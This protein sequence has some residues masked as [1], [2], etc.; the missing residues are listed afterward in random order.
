[1]ATV[2]GKR[3]IYAGCINSSSRTPLVEEGKALEADIVA[4][5]SVTVTATGIQKNANAKTVKGVPFIVAAQVSDFDGSNDLDGAWTQNQVMMAFVPQEDEF[6]NVL[7][8]SGENITARNTPLTVNGAGKFVIATPATDTV[9]CYA[10]EIINLAADGL[11]RVR[12][13]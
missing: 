7:V 13:A 10:D 6:Y 9:Y 3:T 4:G 11:V 2:K 1:M 12:K 8:A 5:M